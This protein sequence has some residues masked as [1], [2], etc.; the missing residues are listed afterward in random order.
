MGRLVTVTT[1][2]LGLGYR[3]A[4]VTTRTASS[5]EGAAAVLRTLVDEGERGLIAM[6]EPF[7]TGLDRSLRRELEARQVP[8]VVPLSAAGAAELAAERRREL[9][10][11]VARAIG[12]EFTFDTEEGGPP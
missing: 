12:Y 9:R 1:E 7:W 6:H 2:E 4:G 3:L 8:L 11:M 5:P 10:A